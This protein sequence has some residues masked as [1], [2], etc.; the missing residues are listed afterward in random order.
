MVKVVVRAYVFRYFKAFHLVDFSAADL[1]S[2]FNRALSQ[3]LVHDGGVNCVLDSLIFG[4][5]LQ[6][7]VSLVCVLSSSLR[8]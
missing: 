1:V 6:V 2:V 3:L 4:S 5:E 8:G 7:L